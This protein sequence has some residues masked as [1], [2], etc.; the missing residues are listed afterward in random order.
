M[1][2]NQSGVGRGLYTEED[3]NRIHDYMRSELTQQG[4]KSMTSDIARITRM[5]ELTHTKL[6]AV[7]ENLEV[8]LQDL[9]SSWS[10]DKEN[11]LLIMI[12]K[13]DLQVLAA[14]YPD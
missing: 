10:V 7:G 14:K 6:N 11:S 4:R 3:V 5:P 12:K 8:M 2:T 13:T 1:V 9:I